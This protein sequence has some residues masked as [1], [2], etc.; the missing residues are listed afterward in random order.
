MFD[1]NDK[2]YNIENYPFD[3]QG[4]VI[5]IQNNPSD[6]YS[7]PF[8]FRSIND[9]IQF[10]KLNR[11]SG[12]N[13][14]IYSGHSDGL[15]FGDKHIYVLNLQD[16]REI[17]LKT[18]GKKCDLII[19]DACLLGNINALETFK[20]TTRYIISSPNYYNYDSFLE[21]KSLYLPPD[22]LY[23]FCKRIIDEYMEVQKKNF[24]SKTF[25]ISIG[26]YKMNSYL[27]KLIEIVHKYK[28]QFKNTCILNKKDDYYLDIGC[29]MN[30]VKD[31]EDFVRLNHVSEDTSHH[32]KDKKLFDQYL[33]KILVYERHYKI[34]NQRN[35]KL[36]I[37][38]KKPYDYLEYPENKFFRDQT[39]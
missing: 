23:N 7:I 33:Q 35:N 37:I 34:S 4:E 5:W 28:D 20:D 30:L 36:L 3:I 8:H 26:L 14:F 24:K 25:M 11:H 31:P 22:D 17:I 27:D 21:L 29:E 12:K 13:I 1:Q 10:F 9:I 18:L 39:K 38:L 16:F 15:L 6:L 2:I 19:C 32:I